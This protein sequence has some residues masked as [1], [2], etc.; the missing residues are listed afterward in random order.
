MSDFRFLI[1]TPKLAAAIFAALGSWVGT[2]SD[3]GARTTT[4]SIL[5]AAAVV[6][7][8]GLFT[9]RNNLKTFW[10]ERALEL[11]AKVKVLEQHAEEKMQE[12]AAFAEAQRDIRHQLKTE[13]STAAAQLE[14]ERAKHDLSSVFARFD[15]LDAVLANRNEIFVRQNALL[16]EILGE[17]R[18]PHSS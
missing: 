15:G 1:P 6:V 18:N 17:L 10:K 5:V 7:I 13:L 9:L 14:V 16:E 12:R 3:F 2:A 8:G 4:I 11:E